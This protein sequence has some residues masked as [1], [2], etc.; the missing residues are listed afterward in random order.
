MIDFNS[1]DP[2]IIDGHYLQ[3]YGFFEKDLE[4]CEA[5][6]Y[7]VI[8]VNDIKYI[9]YVDDNITDRF[10]AQD[11][12]VSTKIVLSNGDIYWTGID[13]E[14]FEDVYKAFIKAKNNFRIAT[15]NEAFELL[16]TNKLINQKTI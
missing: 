12:D 8:D 3:I 16:M 7:L 2:T 6:G 4:Q 14:G 11:F 1:Y 13:R 9:W 15:R 5:M 10:R